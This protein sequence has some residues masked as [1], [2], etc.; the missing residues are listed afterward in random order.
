MPLSRLVLRAQKFNQ[1]LLPAFIVAIIVAGAVTA[2]IK[3]NQVAPREINY[4]QLRAIGEASN[5]Q[6]ISVEG[7]RFTV[8]TR[9]GAVLQAVVTNDAAQ[10]EIVNLFVKNSLPIEFR[11][12]RPGTMATIFN[13]L[14]PVLTLAM[15]GIVGWRVV[16]SMG[17]RSDFHVA[18]GKASAAVTFNEVAGVDEAKNELSEMIEFL[19]DP[20]KFGRLGGRAPQGICFQASGHRKNTARPRRRDRSRRAFSACVRL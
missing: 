17:G 7:E 14:I 3:T 19:R 12:L 13:W 5:A 6:S 20:Q 16:A 15:L 1:V 4:T 8:I 10:Q 18:D 2:F 11:S 9:E